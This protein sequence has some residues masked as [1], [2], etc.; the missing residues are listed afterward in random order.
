MQ[1][2]IPL[3]LSCDVTG[4]P[5]QR[6]ILDCDPAV[7]NNKHRLESLDLDSLRRRRA[8]LIAVA[9]TKTRVALA[10]EQMLKSS[11]A[12]LPP[13]WRHNLFDYI[14]P[15]GRKKQRSMESQLHPN[16]GGVVPR[17]RPI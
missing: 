16:A 11:L 10:M 15:N 8:D 6:D 5:V 7:A 13:A 17:V 12:F 14:D 1:P 4:M 3:E 2:W 9:V